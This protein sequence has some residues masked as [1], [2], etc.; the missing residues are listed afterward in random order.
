VKPRLILGLLMAATLVLP[1]VGSARQLTEQEQIWLAAFEHLARDLFPA[2]TATQ[3]KYCIALRDEASF[4]A[5]PDVRGRDPGSV[6]LRRIRQF[7]ADIVPASMCP[8]VLEPTQNTTRVAPV[9]YSLGRPTQAG[10]F[11][12]IPVSYQVDALR[13]GGWSCALTIVGG[14]WRVIDCLPTW[15]S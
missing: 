4:D 8:Y 2:D 5:P 6:L 10:S 3:R 15:I 14:A 1:A 13:G 11:M 9:V 12:R 7:A